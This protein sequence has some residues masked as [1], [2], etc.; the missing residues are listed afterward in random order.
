MPAIILVVKLTSVSLQATDKN[1]KT[2]HII[3]IIYIYL[4]ITK[5][6][7]DPEGV[8][9]YLAT[10]WAVVIRRP[11]SVAHV[12]IFGAFSSER[13]VRV[14]TL[15]GLRLCSPIHNKLQCSVLSETFLSEPA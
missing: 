2:P 11:Y 8:L 7:P 6:S 9:Q 5:N 3:L 15:A 4:Y 14:G 10:R 12:P 1:T 13:G